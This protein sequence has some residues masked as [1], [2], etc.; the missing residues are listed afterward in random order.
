MAIKLTFA[1]NAAT[2]T[3]DT[4]FSYQENINARPCGVG[5][6]NDG[7]EWFQYSPNAGKGTGAQSIPVGEVAA[8]LLF[9]E[10][11]ADAGIP[12]GG[13]LSAVDV[14]RATIAEEDG[15]Y[16]FRTSSGKGSK[17]VHVRKADLANFIDLTRD[18]FT[19]SL[20]SWEAAK[21]PA[22]KK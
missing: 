17:P 22:K 1:N 3:T 16:T 6:D 11:V 4:K 14:A 12:A 20:R 7:R 9:L 15:V 10:E 19:G 13:A 18:A 2:T 5:L 8:L 21:A